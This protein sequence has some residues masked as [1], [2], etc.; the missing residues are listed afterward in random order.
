VDGKHRSFL[1]V[2][3]L[4]VESIGVPPGATPGSTGAEAER[5]LGPTGGRL[6]DFLGLSPH[7]LD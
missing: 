1:T 7:F 6:V 5:H 4:D 2:H 3:A